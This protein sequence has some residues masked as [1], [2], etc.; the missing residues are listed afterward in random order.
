[1]THSLEQFWGLHRQPPRRTSGKVP[2]SRQNHP[3]KFT[4]YTIRVKVE[5]I[6]ELRPEG[7]L[8]SM[9]VTAEELSSDDF[10][11]CQ[12][13]GGA[14][15]WLQRGGLI[16]PSARRANGAN[17]IIFPHEQDPNFEFEILNQEA[18]SF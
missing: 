2:G 8:P 11:A 1:M 6:L 4:L 12:A 14:V 16:V 3:L 9:G 13:V 15:A 5:G 18:L 10:A 7:L 17:L